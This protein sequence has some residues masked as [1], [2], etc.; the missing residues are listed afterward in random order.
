MPLFTWLPTLKQLIKQVK[1][2]L[3]SDVE[4]ILI[5]FLSQK[6]KRKITIES[7]IDQKRLLASSSTESNFVQLLDTDNRS[8]DSIDLSRML[9]NNLK[10]C[11]YTEFSDFDSRI[12]VTQALFMIHINI[13]SLQKHFDTLVEMLQLLPALPQLI[14]IIKTKINKEPLVNIELEIY[15]FLNA[16]SVTQAGGVG[17]YISKDISFNL[18]GENTHVGGGCEDLWI[19]TSIPGIKRKIVIA[20]LYRHPNSD[21]LAFFENLDKK[22]KSIKIC[23][24]YLL[25][26]LN[27][28]ILNDHSRTIANEYLSM[29]AGNGLFPLITK[30]TRITQESATLI[31]HIF[32]SAIANPIF[33]GITLSDIIDHFFT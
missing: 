16:N 17:I 9:T 5:K 28:N 14:C 23:D 6:L 27:L 12:D 24:M 7:N 8:T 3:Y 13:R 4:S 2:P 33:P 18:I 15:H 30:P 29:L 32:T 26:D 1:Q 10:P 11:V 31:D 25:G 20:L 22:I 19:S 21:P